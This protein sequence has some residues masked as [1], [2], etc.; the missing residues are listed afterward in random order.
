MRGILQIHFSY[1]HRAHIFLYVAPGK[2]ASRQDKYNMRQ[3]NKT[4]RYDGKNQA[5]AEI[6]RIKHSISMNRKAISS[7][8]SGYRPAIFVYTYFGF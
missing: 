6:F 8:A 7:R 5:T 2:I 3:A 4:K 1:F